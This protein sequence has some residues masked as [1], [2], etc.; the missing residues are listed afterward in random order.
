MRDLVVQIALHL[1]QESRRKGSRSSTP[2]PIL[3][4]STFLSLAEDGTTDLP[5]TVP[6]ESEHIAILEYSEM[7]ADDEEAGE[8]DLSG[9]INDWIEDEH[10]ADPAVDDLMSTCRVAF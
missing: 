6:D 5:G 7:E 1:S 3:E 9:R 2:G 4:S 10:A 8:E